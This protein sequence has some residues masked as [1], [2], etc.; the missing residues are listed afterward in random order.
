[1]HIDGFATDPRSEFQTIRRPQERA[2]PRARLHS[3]PNG[4]RL[5][6]FSGEFRTSLSA[7]ALRTSV[8]APER[9]PKTHGEDGLAPAHSSGAIMPLA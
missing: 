9:F 8:P 3:T 1:M 5:K 2:E 6:N 4:A 7:W